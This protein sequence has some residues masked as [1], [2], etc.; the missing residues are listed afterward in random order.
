MRI[1]WFDN[2]VLEI[3]S[4]WFVYV[5][6]L[7]KNPANSSLLTLLYSLSF[8]TFHLSGGANGVLQEITFSLIVQF[9]IHHRAGVTQTRL[10]GIFWEELNGMSQT[11][12]H[13]NKPFL[14]SGSCYDCRT[15]KSLI[16]HFWDRLK[17]SWN[18]PLNVFKQSIRPL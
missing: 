12:Y 16:T 11:N 6:P 10:K 8:S 15:N 13:S 18:Y 5:A 14:C 7:K 2:L 9:I 4:K 17:T 1:G 3:F